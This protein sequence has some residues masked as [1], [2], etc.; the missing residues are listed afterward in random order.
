MLTSLQQ[1]DLQ[2]GGLQHLD[3]GRLETGYLETISNSG[4][5]ANWVD[6]SSDMFKQSPDE[7]GSSF[8]IRQEILPEIFIRLLFR[9]VNC[10]TSAHLPRYMK[11][12]LDVLSEHPRAAQ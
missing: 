10:L 5:E 11:M 8:R 7:V 1:R 4:N 2:I 6:L 3:Q 9:K 12:S